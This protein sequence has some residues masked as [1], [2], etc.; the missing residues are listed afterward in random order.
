MA[1]EF[2]F[3]VTDARKSPDEIQEELRV[4]IRPL[5]V[6]HLK[7]PDRPFYPTNIRSAEC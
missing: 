4:K 5:L 6:S 1:E 2:H 3:E 7:S